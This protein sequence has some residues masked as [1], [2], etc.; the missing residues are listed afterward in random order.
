[1][2]TQLNSTNGIYTTFLGI[3]TE[4]DTAMVSRISKTRACNY[5]TVK[6]AQQFK[7]L[8]DEEFDFTVTPTLFDISIHFLANQVTEFEAQRV[9]GSPGY[10]IPSNGLLFFA[11]SMFPSH[12][13]SAENTKGGVILVKLN[14]KASTQNSAKIV[15][16]LAS[17]RDMTDNIQKDEDTVDITALAE[18]SNNDYFQNNCIRKTVLLVRYVN[19]MKNFLRDM[20]TNA[21]LPSMDQKNGIVI[22]PIDEETKSEVNQMILL[23]KPYRDI[24]KVFISYFEREMIEIGDP[25]LNAE[26]KKLITI[27]EFK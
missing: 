7:K 17:Y 23:S 12:K 9:Y 8:M 18:E 16:F 11:D 14:K 21:K 1:L 10:E 2:L 20:R 5:L 26:L 24:I 19:F 27:S 6:D 13:E 22:P 15:K 4:F 25:L 3:G